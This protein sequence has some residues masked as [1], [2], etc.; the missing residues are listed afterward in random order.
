MC[1][2]IGGAAGWASWLMQADTTQAEY[3]YEPIDRDNPRIA[4]VLRKDTRLGNAYADALHKCEVEGTGGALH[5]GGTVTSA[6]VGLIENETHPCR[7][8]YQSAFGP[9]IEFSNTLPV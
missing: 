5:R 2:T 7:E 1:R 6:W 3:K 8:V 9:S 4:A